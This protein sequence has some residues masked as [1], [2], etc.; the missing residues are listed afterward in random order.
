[1]ADHFP[2]RSIGQIFTKLNLSVVSWRNRF[3]EREDESISYITTAYKHKKP[4]SMHFCTG[5]KVA[6]P[7]TLVGESRATG[8]P[9]SRDS[10]NFMTQV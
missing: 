7:R 1:M 10:P 9:F 6:T 3:S 2:S 4:F 5:R 8:D